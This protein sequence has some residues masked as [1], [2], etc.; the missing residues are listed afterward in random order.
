M[1]KVVLITGA[2]SGLGRE[3]ALKYGAAGCSVCVADIHQQRG[4]ETVELLAAIGCDAIFQSLDVRLL[5]DFE[6]AKD[7][8]LL[9]WGRVDC[10]INNAGVASVGSFEDTPLDTWDWMLAINLLGPVKGCKVFTPLF[11]QQAIG[12]FI[13]IASMA[14]LI[15]APGM[16]EY[17]VAKAGLVALSETLSSELK[18]YGIATSVVCPAFFSTNLGDSLRSTNTVSKE[19][20][21]KLLKDDDLNAEQIAT[22]I[23]A[24]AEKKT[25]L[26]LPHKKAAASYQLKQKNPEAFYQEMLRIAQSNASKLDLQDK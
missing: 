25:F 10:V 20:F 1:S 9:R 6:R 7:V 16:A 26:I 17:N 19:I 8:M 12:Q 11:K 15:N 4:E 13:N 23:M 2:A 22:F 18:P 3:L 21:N 5:E 24:E 14:G